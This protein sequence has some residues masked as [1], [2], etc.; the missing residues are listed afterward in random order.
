MHGSF[1]TPV[2]CTAGNDGWIERVV[3]LVCQVGKA[4]HFLILGE[5]EGLENDLERDVAI[6]AHQAGLDFPTTLAVN[7]GISEI[8]NDKGAF[9]LLNTPNKQVLEKKMKE[10]LTAVPSL[11]VNIY[12]SGHAFEDGSW[13]LSEDCSYTGEDLCQ[14]IESC[15]KNESR[16]FGGNLKVYLDSCYGLRFA[17]AVGMTDGSFLGMLEVM[18]KPDESDEESELESPQN[19]ELYADAMIQRHPLQSLKKELGQLVG[20]KEVIN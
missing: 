1:E 15:Q 13:F 4:L 7:Y 16:R 10:H 12:Y 18:L 2:S 3:N 9:V 11:D 17:K 6:I 8:Y 20:L 5:A 19:P 14:F